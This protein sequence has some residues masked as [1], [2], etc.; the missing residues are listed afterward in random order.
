M[1]PV[2][3]EDKTKKTTLASMWKRAETD[4]PA[5]AGG[6]VVLR[7][8]LMVPEPSC[9][10][11]TGVSFTAIRSPSSLETLGVIVSQRL[12]LK[13]GIIPIESPCWAQRR[14]G[15]RPDH[16]AT[17]DESIGDL[18]SFES[19]PS[20]DSF[21]ITRVLK[22]K[23]TCFLSHFPSLH[24]FHTLPATHRHHRSCGF[25]SLFSL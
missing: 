16:R 23:P 3:K 13:K 15:P 1:F 10:G 5:G 8:E 9:C 25:C 20:A 2:Q 17:G 24:L 21:L 14:E 7:R 22:P 4:R 12:F 6:C 18:R 11:W 19:Q